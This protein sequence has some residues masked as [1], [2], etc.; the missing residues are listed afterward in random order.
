MLLTSMLELSMKKK[1]KS[2]FK[3]ECWIPQFG[4]DK[5][6]PNNGQMPSNVPCG[7]G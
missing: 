7:L 1:I 4:K 3:K 5:D 6:L 2:S